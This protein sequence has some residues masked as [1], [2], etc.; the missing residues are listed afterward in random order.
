M[1]KLNKAALKSIIKEC[2]MEILAEAAAPDISNNRPAPRAKRK[3]ETPEREF[4]AGI[5]EEKRRRTPAVDVSQV[6]S[7]P[8]MA[9][10]FEDTAK[11]TLVEQ[12]ANESSVPMYGGS[13]AGNPRQEHVPANLDN[14]FGDSAR[15]WADIAFRSTNSKK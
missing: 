9:A 10:I 12:A 11:S 6:T 8:V 5:K 15:K 2:L 1:A 13:P 3:R 4:L 7:D 14:V